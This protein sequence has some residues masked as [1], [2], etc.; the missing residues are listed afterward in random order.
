MGVILVVFCAIRGFFLLFF[1]YL[2]QNL[3]YLRKILENNVVL[4]YT[5]RLA[6]CDVEVMEKAKN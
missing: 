2:W 6:I 3:Y 1:A 4:C 5:V